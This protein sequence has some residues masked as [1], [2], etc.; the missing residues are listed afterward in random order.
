MV[1]NKSI[2][3]LFDTDIGTDIDDAVCLAYLLRHPRC[4]LL[5]ITTVSGHPSTRAALADAV[6]RAAGRQDIPIHSGNDVGINMGIVQPLCTQAEILTQYP[7]QAPESFAPYTAVPFLRDQILARPGEL[8]LLAVGPLTNLAILFT[9][10]PTI[11]AKL[12]RLVI[13]GGMFTWSVPGATSE[14]N[15]KSDPVAAAIVFRAPVPELLAVG[16]DVTTQCRMPYADCLA[17]FEQAGGPLSVV[18][19]AAKAWRHH[20]SSPQLTFHDPLAGAVVFHPELCQFQAGRISVELQSEHF[21]GATLFDAAATEKNHK[22]A[23]TVNAEGFFKNY[24]DI[25]ASDPSLWPR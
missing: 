5:G 7:H 23:Q 16:L 24:F 12:K 22:T 6:C 19:A 11:P 18:A 2:P 17:R 14:W 15:I 25:A 4:E 20:C 9:L 8:T 21:I 13:M 1:H 10:D 3:L